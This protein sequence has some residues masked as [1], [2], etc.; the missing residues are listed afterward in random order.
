MKTRQL[1][2]FILLFFT[3]ATVQA[4]DSFDGV[5]G[6]VWLDTD[7]N[8]IQAH[9]G[10]VQKIGNKWWWVGENRDG[11]RDIKLYS[12]D[13]LYNWKSE[14]SAMRVLSNRNQLDNDAYFT[15]LYGD[16]TAAE[17]D[18][19]YQAIRSNAV[20]ERP[21][22]IYNANTGK[23]VIWFHADDSNYGAAAAGVAISDNI[24]GP[25]KFIKRSRLHQLP[26]NEYHQPNEWYEEPA[27][28]G[29]SRDMNLFVDDDGKAYIIYS[30]EENRTMFISR[31]NEDYT[32]LDVPQTPVGLAKNGVDFIRIFPGAQREAPALF[33]Y[34]GKYYLITSGATSWDPNQA[35]YWT[36]DE[37]FG[38]WTDKGDPCVSEPGIPYPANLTFRTQSTNVIPVDPANG[39][40]IYMGDRWNSGNLKDSRY[41][42]LPVIFTPIGDVELRSISNWNLSLFETIN[43]VK[44]KP[45]QFADIYYRDEDLP[46]VL[47]IEV[48]GENGW[49]DDEISITWNTNIENL[50]PASLT[51]INGSF[52][53]NGTLQTFSVRAVNIPE[54][55]L[56]FIDCGATN[57]SD[58]YD[59]ITGLAPYLINTTTYDQSFDE[60]TGW[61]YTGQIGADVDYKN[62]ESK[63]A[64]SSGWWAY[65]NK[66]IDYKLAVNNGEY[67]LTT[68]F[69]EWW[70]TGRDMRISLLYQNETGNNRTKI[71]G[72]F[73]NRTESTQDYSFE[74]NDLNSDNPY[75]TIRVAKTGNPDPV[76]SWLSLTSLDMQTSIDKII[77]LNHTNTLKIYPNP[78]KQSQAVYIEVNANDEWLKDADIIV[79]NISGFTVKQQK[80]TGNR[81]LVDLQVP[82]G[83]YIIHLK[84]KYAKIIVR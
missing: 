37:I 54:T 16:L 34:D 63:D 47:Q 71:L 20:I 41:I 12:S 61:G 30:S 38:E 76:M 13:D 53:I 35:R 59:G 58:L 39:Q 62:P 24:T 36:A 23:Y 75:I 80:I 84:D 70:D 27:N 8:T 4:K 49:E 77:V 50:P 72:N 82:Q 48:R 42:W 66:N 55:L 11:N 43:Q 19:V 67:R 74:I 57:G 51:S 7:G 29:M 40:F 64:F 83:I 31:L 17:K 65:G 14:G 69:Q 52:E 25:Y 73:Y 10:Q 3:I 28:R 18:L 32:D 78:V 21:K 33:K 44:L 46:T 9:G 60:N 15:A 1:F 26:A 68:G 5:T 56:Y 81:T 6:G 22:L 2:L 45:D 79:Q